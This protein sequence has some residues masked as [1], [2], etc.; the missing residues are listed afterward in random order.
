MIDLNAIMLCE[1]IQEEIKKDNW[2]MARTWA[3]M[4]NAIIGQ[5]EQSGSAPANKTQEPN[6][7]VSVDHK[8]GN[9]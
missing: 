5:H 2:Q 3:N 4:L 1:K 9:T 8:Q 6:E 7:T